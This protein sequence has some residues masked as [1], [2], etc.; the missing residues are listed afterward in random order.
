M[1]LLLSIMAILF[2]LPGTDGGWG[3]LSGG[4]ESNSVYYF[5]DPVVG[6]RINKWGSNNYLKLDWQRDSLSAGLQAEWYPQALAGYP[7]ELK[8]TGLSSLYFSWTHDFIKLTVGSLHEQLGSG[9]LLRTWEDRDMGINNC[10]TG[11]R[12]EFTSRGHKV[13]A[14]V[15]GGLP[16][17]GVWPTPAS[18]VA[19][20]D[21]SFDLGAFGLGGGIVDRASFRTDDGIVL[22]AS[23]GG[24]ELP[25]NVLSWAARA[26]FSAGGFN[27][28]AEYVGKA[29][30]FYA[31][32]LPG[33]REQYILPPGNAQIVELSYSIEN[34][35]ASLTLRRLENMTSRIFLTSAAPSVANTLNYL[36]SL[37]MQQSYMLAGLNPYVTYAD[38]EASFQGD[39]YYTFRRGSKLGGRYGMKLHVCGCWIDVL[40]FALPDRDVAYLAYRDINIDL[41][42]R[43]TRNFRTVFFVSIQENSPTH[44]NGKRTDAQNVFVVDASYRLS[45][46]MSV[47]TELQ[48]LYS[49]ELTRDWMAALLEFSFA[50]HWSFSVSDMYNH[51]STGV[52]YYNVSASY[53]LSSFN[54]SL[55]A[56]R[57]REGMVC[58]GGVCRWQPAWSGVGFRAQWSF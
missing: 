21:V 35:S 30:D 6:G 11:G 14:K 46:E 39:V 3:K 27:A 13:N 5:D 19:D 25:S 7:S 36:P 2:S 43:W 20:A 55:I 17:Y 44:G 40:P 47:R 54:I 33:A 16:K 10:I 34:F 18:A 51:G 8:G 31:E 12:V 45:P 41:E 28:K 15:F 4:L 50:P 38:G 26:R 42:R 9:I 37:C 32:Q 22:L 1:S 53:A 29:P 52:H 48:Y 49:Q 23:A 57:N 58:S 24:F 56:G